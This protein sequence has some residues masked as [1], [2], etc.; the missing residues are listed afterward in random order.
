MRELL[1]VGAALQNQVRRE[2]ENPAGGYFSSHDPW[3]DHWW[4]RAWFSGATLSSRDLGKSSAKDPRSLREI[5][6]AMTPELQRLRRV[7]R[8]SAIHRCALQV[9]RR[10]IRK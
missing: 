4:Q 10:S 9:N 8:A 3:C 1:K 5:V 2:V 6:D 7:P